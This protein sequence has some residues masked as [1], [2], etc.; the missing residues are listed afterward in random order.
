MKNL[1]LCLCL[2]F[3]LQATA[4]TYKSDK[5]N[6]DQKERKVF[7]S[8]KKPKQFV[9]PPNVVK[10]TVNSLLF[11]A[12]SVQYE[13][14]VRKNMSLALGLIYR[15]KSKSLYNTYYQESN[16]ANWG[17]SKE[18]AAMY[19]SSR[20]RTLMITPEF[21]YY[22]RKKSP[23]GLY[24]APFA[25]FRSDRLTFNY[26]YRENNS[27]VTKTAEAKFSQNAIGGGLLFGMQILSK[28]G[29]SIDL[30]FVGPW[31]GTMTS[32]IKGKLNTANVNEFERAIIASNI[33]PLYYPFTEGVKGVS[34][35]ANG[36]VGK[37]SNSTLGFR[38]VGIN[39]GYNF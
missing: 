34:W 11:K 3:T 20:L 23:K 38:F 30:W 5:V 18:T 15:P 8:K 6:T 22:F 29:L 21:R 10:L 39:L 25:R 9:Y 26:T 16:S 2:L 35:D 24:L 32:S 13:R 36:L 31:Y 4:Q 1:V 17:V 12:L 7:S 33:D 14:K 28:K 19:Q 37:Y 27:S